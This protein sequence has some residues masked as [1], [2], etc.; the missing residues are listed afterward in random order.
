L[1][2]VFTLR[3]DEIEDHWFW[4]E[5]LLAKV[6]KPDWT[7]GQVKADLVAAKAQLWGLLD[8]RSAPQGLLITRIEN[9]HETRFGLVW[10]AAGQ[11]LEH[12]RS[13]LSEVERWFK[14]KGCSRVDIAGRRGWER[15]LPDYEFR[16][17]V[18]SKEL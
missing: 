8:D 2:D 4:I 7:L 13:F 18:L 14:S 10:I 15:A 1:A 11:G 16:A 5:R 3:S 12:A 17:V 6:D 9:F